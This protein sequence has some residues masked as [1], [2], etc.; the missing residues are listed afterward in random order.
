MSN[1]EIL[2]AKKEDFS[3]I[4][5]KIDLFFEKKKGEFQQ[6]VP[7]LY[8][9]GINTF[10]KHIVAKDENKIVGVL[11][12]IKK[13]LNIANKVLNVIGIGTVCVDQNYRGRGIM[14]RMFDLLFKT[15]DNQ[16]DAYSLFGSYDRYKYF[17]F[18]KLEQSLGFKINKAYHGFTFLHINKAGEQMR[19]LYEKQNYRVD[20][21]DT[22]DDIINM[23]SDKTFTIHKDNK[24]VGYLI[25]S[26]S[27]NLV[28]ELVVNDDVLVNSI[29][30]SFAYFLNHSINFK[31]TRVNN[32]QQKY[33]QYNESLEFDERQLCRTIN[34]NIK[35]IY[36][37]RNDLI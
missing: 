13:E 15:F 23:W 21:V 10:D 11:A 6:L 26:E 31:V 3:Q 33:V 8:K 20:R 12:F 2:F 7:I 34:K 32:H 35:D 24:E 17:G 28:H 25:Y 37:P 27:K 29:L 22:F 19:V 30:E 9:E 1:I 5:E 14:T 4:L 16:I 18:N 36:V